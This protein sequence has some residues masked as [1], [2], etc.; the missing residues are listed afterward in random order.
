MQAAKVT[1]NG[2]IT[3]PIDVRARLGLVDGSYMLFIEQGNGF[4]VVNEN[5]IDK[6]NES[7]TNGWS[8]GFTKSFLAH[9]TP[10]EPLIDEYDDIPW[11]DREELL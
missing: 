11:T 2:Q 4:F 9:E 3:V 1:S 5:S 10:Y 8:E 7:G 6:S